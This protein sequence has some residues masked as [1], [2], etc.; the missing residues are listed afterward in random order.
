MQKAT[1][2]D[3]DNTKLEWTYTIFLEVK[4]FSGWKTAQTE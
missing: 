2:F 4:Y 3:V 1:E